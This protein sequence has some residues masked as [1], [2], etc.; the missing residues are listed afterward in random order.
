MGVL[1][2]EYQAVVAAV[3]EVGD[4]LCSLWPV[5]GDASHLC[6][7]EKG[8]G[9]LVSKADYLANEL[10]IKRIQNCFPNDQIHSEE[11]PLINFRSTD[12]WR[13]I[14]DPLDGTK[15]FLAGR[16]DFSVLVCRT[17]DGEPDFAVM[18]FPV[19]N[20]LALAV[21]GEG[22][23]INGVS[24]MV[25]NHKLPRKAGI[26]V[27]NTTI[28]IQSDS[29]YPDSM[30]SGLAQLNVAQGTFDG[31]IIGLTTHREWD[32]AAPSLIVKESGG[33]V[34]DESGTPILFNHPGITAKIYIAASSASYKTL[35]S[36]ITPYSKQSYH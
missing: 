21:C 29:I 13:W 18:Y 16:D 9:S 35:F 17:K 10:L 22:A 2:L 27:R 28:N 32:I 14:I 3:K 30:D 36:S 15:S 6:P 20:V 1:N 19:R 26:Y 4:L 23:T 5:N 7:T 12:Q 11:S 34:T 24:S 33:I 31:A 8:D 25:A